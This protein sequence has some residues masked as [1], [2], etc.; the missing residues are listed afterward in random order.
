MDIFDIEWCHFMSW[1]QNNGINVFYI[2]RNQ[3]Y[4]TSAYKLLSEFWWA[5]VVPAR[6]AMEHG[7]KDIYSYAPSRYDSRRTEIAK[8]TKELVSDITPVLF[9]VN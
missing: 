2:P 5:N 6:L 3:M 9:R 4:W 7:T 8:L 1:T